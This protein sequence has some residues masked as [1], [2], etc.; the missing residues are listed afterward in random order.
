MKTTTPNQAI[1]QILKMTATE[2]ALQDQ[3]RP[4]YGADWYKNTMYNKTL[5]GK[6]NAITDKI[7]YY[8][9]FISEYDYDNSEL[10]CQLCCSYE[11]FIG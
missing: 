4:E 9:Q 11:D 3:R 1:A 5:D 10:P 6:I 2:S 8:S 7:T